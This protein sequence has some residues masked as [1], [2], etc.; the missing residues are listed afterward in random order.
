MILFLLS[1]G[2]FRVK[3]I[4]EYN[5]QKTEINLRFHIFSDHLVYLLCFPDFFLW[6]SMKKYTMSVVRTFNLCINL[7]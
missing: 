5:R 3:R 7:I 6:H 4:E 1:T 2:A